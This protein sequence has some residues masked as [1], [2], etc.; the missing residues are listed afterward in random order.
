M[1]I[2]QLQSQNAL[3]MSKSVWGSR[4]F[5]LK[6]MASVSLSEGKSLVGR[7]RLTK[8]FIEQLQNYYGLAIRNNQ[9]SVAESFL[10][11]LYGLYISIQFNE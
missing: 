1:M 8:P 2:F 11:K 10:Q 3:D 4:L 5:R 9:N 7:N 6:K